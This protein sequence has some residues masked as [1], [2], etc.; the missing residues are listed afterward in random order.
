MITPIKIEINVETAQCANFFQKEQRFFN[1]ELKKAKDLIKKFAKSFNEYSSALGKNTGIAALAPITVFGRRGAGKTSFL[2][3]LME[4]SEEYAIPLGILEPNL[5]EKREL[6]LVS[7]VA[8]IMRKVTEYCPLTVNIETECK[9]SLDR[10]ETIQ[11]CLQRLASRFSVLV[12]TATIPDR[13]RSESAISFAERALAD[14]E[15]GLT[16]REDFQKFVSAAK[17]A[18]NKPLLLMIDDTDVAHERCINVL[19]TV[20]NYLCVNGLIVVVAADEEFLEL[21]VARDNLRWVADLADSEAKLGDSKGK[22]NRTTLDRYR[23][24]QYELVEQYLSKALP[25]HLRIHLQDLATLIYFGD[26]DITLKG[27]DKGNSR[28]ESQDSDHNALK[29]QT[30][31]ALKVLGELMGGD[32]ALAAKYLPKSNRSLVRLSYLLHRYTCEHLSLPELLIEFDYQFRIARRSMGVRGWLLRQLRD[33][34]GDLEL[35]EWIL[36]QSITTRRSFNLERDPYGGID[37]RRIVPVLVH[38]SW[39]YGCR[40]H[41][42]ADAFLSYGLKVVLPA[43]QVERAKDRQ[44]VGK[45][46]VYRLV[47]SETES[48]TSL[49]GRLL[50]WQAESWQANSAPIYDPKV[51]TMGHVDVPKADGHKTEWYFRGLPEIHGRDSSFFMGLA[52]IADLCAIWTRVLETKSQVND[53]M[54]G[55]TEIEEDFQKRKKVLTTAIDTAKRAAKCFVD[56]LGNKNGNGQTNAISGWDTNWEEWLNLHD[57]LYRIEQRY[58]VLPARVTGQVFVFLLNHWLESAGSSNR[59]QLG[60]APVDDFIHAFWYAIITKELAWRQEPQVPPMRAKGTFKKVTPKEVTGALEQARNWLEQ[61]NRGPNKSEQILA[62]SLVWL[63]CPL[64]AVV[65]NDEV[66]CKVE[67]YIATVKKSFS[68]S[69]NIGDNILC[70]V[71]ADVAWILDACSSLK[72]S[73]DSEKKNSAPS[74]R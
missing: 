36:E 74:S 31:N 62:H 30:P 19:E 58:Q 34:K 39:I 66:K 2:R 63:T 67:D 17:D 29:T 40:S 15:A 9:H 45:E 70:S 26:V 10:Q 16:L 42:R 43:Y 46:L 28:L 38:A 13:E 52:R 59:E 24:Q 56:E 33:G 41:R 50:A 72:A 18:V 1:E 5:I 47:P 53:A 4:E 6:F 14:S 22:L 64:F 3:S 11:R 69:L 37:D 54:K 49:V 7:V 51:W 44:A 35:M 57:H 27:K 55:D 48:C 65:Y 61:S 21:Q 60:N 68:E 20:R 32:C 23:D 8:L 12:P 71:I 73:N 25:Q